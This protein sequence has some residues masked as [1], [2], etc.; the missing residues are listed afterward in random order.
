MYGNDRAENSLALGLEGNIIHLPI[1][2]TP[3]HNTTVLTEKNKY[4]P[5]YI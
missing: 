2:L 5:A 1:L 4:V 3:H